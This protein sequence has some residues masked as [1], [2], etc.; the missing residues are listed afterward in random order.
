MKHK[1]PAIDGTLTSITCD[2][3][4][5]TWQADTVDAA[6]FTS[7]DFTGGYRQ[8]RFGLN[9][10]GQDLLELWFPGVHS[11]VGGGYRRVLI[12]AI[13]GLGADAA[14]T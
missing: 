14:E 13:A 8:N 5:Q 7:I 1:I 4:G 11:D 12:E 2:R 6:E 9:T 10:P 3:C